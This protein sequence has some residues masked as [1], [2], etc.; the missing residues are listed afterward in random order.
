M[1]NRQKKIIECL[2]TYP[3]ATMDERRVITD[4][5][6]ASIAQ[7][8]IEGH[9][10]FDFRGKFETVIT[11]ESKKKIQES[12][13][14]KLKEIL[15]KKFER[16]DIL[17]GV[18]KDCNYIEESDPENPGHRCG[19]YEDVWNIYVNIPHVNPEILGLREVMTEFEYTHNSHILPL[20]IGSH[21]FGE[22]LVVDLVR[23]PHVLVCSAPGMGKTTLLHN[24]IISLLY[25]K[26]PEEVQLT[27]IGPDE[28]NVYESLR[29]SYLWQPVITDGDNAIS[30]I[31]TLNTEVDRRYKLLKQA[32]VLN[33]SEYIAASSESMPYIVTIIDEY[34]DLMKTYGE[35]FESRIARIAQLG[36][37]VGIH[38]IISTNKI[39]EEVITPKIKANFPSRIALKANT[40]EE[41]RLI[42]DE[43]GAEELEHKGQVLFPYQGCTYDLQNPLVTTAEIRA[44][45]SNLIEIW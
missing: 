22:P 15:F 3:I 12:K 17:V 16:G 30:A 40:S 28:F 42:L 32:G 9:I 25:S 13:T 33:I 26:T 8:G 44:V 1:D 27:L 11:F 29:K 43:P 2:R 36:H 45:V 7:A 10:G 4:T 41:S 14:D 38:I 24:L 5:M 6:L 18:S 21:I 34:S 39:T 20:P 31:E 23:A 37:A 35:E 19:H